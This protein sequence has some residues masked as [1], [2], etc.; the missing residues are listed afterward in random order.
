VPRA[1]KK[2]RIDSWSLAALVAAAVAF[3]AFRIPA[4]A[5][6]ADGSRFVTLVEI[7]VLTVAA[8]LVLLAAFGAAHR[9]RL[10]ALRAGWPDSVVVSCLLTPGFGQFVSGPDAVLERQ[11]GRAV[12]NAYVVLRAGADGLTVYRGIR[13]PWPYVKVPRR[14]IV[15]VRVRQVRLGA[16]TPWVVVVVIVMAGRRI[17]LPLP[18]FKWDRGFYPRLLKRAGVEAAAQQLRRALGVISGDDAAA[19]VNLELAHAGLR[20]EDLG[21]LQQ[22]VNQG[23][24]L[25]EPRHVMHYSYFGSRQVAEEAAAEARAAGWIAAVREPL[26]EYADQWGM[27][28]EH[29]EAVLTVSFVIDSTAWFEMLAREHDGEYDGWEAAAQPAVDPA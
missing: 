27:V 14:S 25:E 29:P 23:A 11:R 9:R 13:R 22:L 17:P 19:N 20:V 21:T 3:A 2:W 18:L 4:L 16:R 6:Y 1:P 28:A 8:V 24:D 10:A 5:R 26:P 15:D 7:A 12:E